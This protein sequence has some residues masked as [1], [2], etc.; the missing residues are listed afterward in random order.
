MTWQKVGSVTA[1]G[2]PYFFTRLVG[3]VRHWVSWNRRRKLWEV[4]AEKKSGGYQTLGYFPTAMAGK[5]Y[6]DKGAR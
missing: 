5:R 6:V 2:K 4:S 3:N 1:G